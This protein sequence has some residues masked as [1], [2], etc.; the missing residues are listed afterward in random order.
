M[1]YVNDQQP[2]DDSESPEAVPQAK[3]HPDLYKKT[4]RGGF[5]LVAERIVQQVLSFVRLLIL[6]RLLPPRE[7][8]VLGIA[9]LLLMVFETF[10]QTG[11]ATAL[12]Q[13]KE[14]DIHPY[15][16]TAWTVGVVRGTLL[17]ALFVMIAPLTIPFFDGN[18][19]FR[20]NDFT[21][22][23]ELTA[24][25]LDPENRVAAY[26]MDRLPESTR[27]QIAEI[28]RL[29]LEKGPARERLSAGFNQLTALDDFYRAD[30]FADVEFSAYAREL[31]SS[32][33]PETRQRAN[34]MILQ[35]VWPDDLQHSVLNRPQLIWIIRAIGIVLLLRAFGNP[36]ILYFTKTLRFE[37]NF[38]L[39]V[40]GTVVN[41]VATVILAFV[42]HSVWALVFGQLLAG[43]MGLVMSYVLYPW[44]PRFGLDRDRLGQMWRF[45]R[46]I[47]G[48][49]W[50]ELTLT[51]GDSL[52]VTRMLGA[53]SLGMYQMSNRLSSLPI[54]ELMSVITR[55]TFPA[56]SR[57]QTDLERLT[58]AVLKSI[59]IASVLVMP[60]VAAIILFADDI[61][62]LFMQET[63]VPMIST[64]RI[65][66]IS[67]FF[68]SIPAGAVCHSVGKPKYLTI[69]MG[70]RVSLIALLFYP[71]MK[72][73][74]LDGMAWVMVISGVIVLPLGYLLLKR[75]LQCPIRVFAERQAAQLIG[76]LAMLGIGFGIKQWLWTTPS[77][78]RLL[79]LAVL[80]LAVYAAVCLPLT[81]VFKAEWLAFFKEQ[82]RS[83]RQLTEKKVS[84]ASEGPA[85][86][87]QVND[88]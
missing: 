13:R 26:V 12:I 78:L 17:F 20:P 47:T 38:I 10:T 48:L 35:H 1:D 8:G 77:F 71:M 60:A 28:E 80:S 5:W 61:V 74:G 11:F 54:S 23:A 68:K 62:L 56:F 59:D 55:A 15:L 22:P 39:H 33:S 63:W 83:V 75:A 81:R 85:G 87:D 21:R 36:A 86:N 69:I 49:S 2:F 70:I 25:L 52:L 73:Y 58:K 72:V 64:L 44:C 3:A 30:V 37:M 42:L 82:W 51:M 50:L 46:W 65:L 41:V 14:D 57:I 6:A 27:Q 40:G 9:M 7:F 4:V 53:S 29:G 34:R 88:A 24:Q 19:T 32:A 43:V 76:A 18:G 31:I 16:P 66:A 67:G 84:C 45:G 79:T